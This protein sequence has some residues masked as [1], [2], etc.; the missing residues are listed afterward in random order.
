MA[1]NDDGH[2]VHAVGATDCPDGGRTRNASRDVFVGARLSIRNVSQCFPDA[3][4]ERGARSVDRNG[5]GV[6]PAG[7]IFVELSSQR[8]QMRMLGGHQRSLEASAQDD[9][10]LFE[11][12]AI[13]EFEQAYA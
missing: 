11:H 3:L 10:L 13:R 6:S 9:E 4:L 12:A 1:G 2:A 8:R 5:E 7:E